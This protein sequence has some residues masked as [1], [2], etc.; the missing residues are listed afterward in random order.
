MHE[1]YYVYCPSFVHFDFYSMTIFT[2]LN[3]KYDL[4]FQNTS[5]RYKSLCKIFSVYAINCNERISHLMDAFNSN[6]SKTCFYDVQNNEGAKAKIEIQQFYFGLRPVAFHQFYV[7]FFWR[8]SS[9]HQNHFPYRQLSLSS[10]FSTLWTETL[11]N[12]F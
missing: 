5:I 10:N 3:G 7:Y 2:A 12:Y 4:K 11:L 6:F 9:R 8:M 1:M